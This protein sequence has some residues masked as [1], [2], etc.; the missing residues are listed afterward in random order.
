[1]KKFKN[2]FKPRKE[3]SQSRAKETVNIILEATAHILDKTDL[4]KISTNQIAKKAGVSIG[5]LYQYFPSKESI[6]FKFIETKL[7]EEYE[8][9]IEEVINGESQSIETFIDMTINF[10]FERFDQHQKTRLLLFYFIPRGISQNIYDIEDKIKHEIIEKLKSFPQIDSKN[11]DSKAH[12]I[13]HS[14]VGVVHSELPA[15][16]NLNRD[17]LIEE[18][19]SM[20]MKYLR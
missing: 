10:V 2:P 9:F 18:L 3:G 5:S 11:L 1:M 7:N 16:R 15:N 4:S 14:L 19:K 17:N 12:V 13:I 6:F 8:K 20:L